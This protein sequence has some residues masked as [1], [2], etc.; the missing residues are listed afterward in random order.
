MPDS[1]RW[2]PRIGEPIGHQLAGAALRAAEADV[3]RVCGEV[4][5]RIARLSPG[6]RI[7]TTAL[8]PRD[9]AAQVREPLTAGC[10]V[11]FVGYVDRAGRLAAIPV[12]LGWDGAVY[13]RA[14]VP[15]PARH[16]SASD[17]CTV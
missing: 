1:D 14:A 12:E 11:A 2:P 13:P 4:A 6:S 17:R 7:A 10:T 9:L 5:A 15:L 8:S 3:R 16:V